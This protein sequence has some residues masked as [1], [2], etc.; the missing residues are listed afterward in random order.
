M[1][2]G[3]TLFPHVTPPPIRHAVQLHIDGYRCHAK[4]CDLRGDLS[5][6]VR[7]A[8]QRQFQV[9]GNWSNWGGV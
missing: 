4:G 8:V 9:E 7:H 6:A 3:S 2:R 1:P 5:W